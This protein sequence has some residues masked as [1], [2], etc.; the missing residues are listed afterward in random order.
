MPAILTHDFFGKDMLARGVDAIGSSID[1]QDAFLLGN[2][3]PDPLFYLVLS[4]STKEF[5]KLGD[6]MHHDNPSLLLTA[7]H[8]SL[9]F[10]TEDEVPVGRAYVAGFACH[11]SLDRA[12]HPWI[13]CQQYAFC[14]A[15]IEGLTERNGGDVHAEIERE[16]DEI[17]L[18]N[19]R[20]LTIRT[21]KPYVEVLHGRT[22]TLKAIGKIYSYVAARVYGMH[23]SNDLFETAVRD[24]RIIQRFFYSPNMVTTG[25]VEGIET[26]LMKKEYSFYKCMAHRYNTSMTSDFDNHEHAEWKNP[27]TGALSNDSFWDIFYRAQD[28]AAELIDAILS[29]DFDE[30]RARELSG[31][32]N[33]SG[34]PVE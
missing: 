13:F 15:G 3:G 5:H 18:V 16:L 9:A 23:P 20:G 30:T 32:L 7:M 24:F 29:D 28:V 22:A 4:P 33:F 11:Y 17:V 1:E 34:E 14:N 12:E 26:L 10:L 8:E 6:T 2:Q 25:A 31:G 27:F 21:Y 19:K